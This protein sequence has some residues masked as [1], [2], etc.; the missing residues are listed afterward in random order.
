MRRVSVCS[1][2]RTVRGTGR[3]GFTLVELLV[4]IGIIALLVAILMPALSKARGQAQW[5]ACLS[6][7]KQLG[8]ALQMYAQENKG[9]LPRPASN[10]NGEFPDDIIIWREPPTTPGFTVNDTVLAKYLNAFNDKLQT[11]FR[12]PTDN[13]QDRPPQSGFNFPFRYSYTMNEAWDSIPNPPSVARLILPR[14]K[15]TQVQ[16]PADKCL[17]V[18]ENNPNDGRFVYGNVGAGSADALAERHAK[19]G[20][21]LFHD[22]HADRRYWKELKD[23]GKSMV[24]DIYAR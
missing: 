18:E 15:I 23:A 4:V 22:M 5:A 24:F 3:P 1:P 10:G 19:Q 12:C 13:Y 16:R 20:N 11:I 8:N 2:R 6:N 17:L 7:L 21:V 9:Y 14:P